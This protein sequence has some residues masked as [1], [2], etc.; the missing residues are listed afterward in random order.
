MDMP[1]PATLAT[2]GGRGIPGMD[3]MAL[4]DD[5]LPT[6]GS[7]PDS[8]TMANRHEHQRQH[9]VCAISTLY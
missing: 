7:V 5:P 1:R 4:S 2:P 9:V 8:R 3:S 6:S